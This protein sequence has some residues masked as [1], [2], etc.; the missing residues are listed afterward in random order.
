MVEQ[1][2]IRFRVETSFGEDALFNALLFSKGIRMKKVDSV[3][4]YYVQRSTSI[5]HTDEDAKIR[6]S[7]EGLMFCIQEVNKFSG[8]QYSTAHWVQ[9]FVLNIVSHLMRGSFSVREV[10]QIR[11]RLIAIG[12]FPLTSP[13]RTERLYFTALAHPWLLP[14]VRT[15]VRVKHSL[16]KG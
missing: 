10:R 1:Y 5:S 15:T 9:L 12:V 13:W 2:K 3:I 7:I 8:P 4:Y 6:R 11:D 16:K 14:L